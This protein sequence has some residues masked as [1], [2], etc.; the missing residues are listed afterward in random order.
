METTE[1]SFLPAEKVAQLLPES[2]LDGDEQV[3]LALKPSLWLVVFFSFQTVLICLVVALVA[4][5]WL[6]GLLAQWLIIAAGLIALGRIIFALLQWA[7]RVYVLTDQRVIVV[8]GVFTVTIFQCRLEKIQ[9]TFMLLPFLLRLLRLGHI[10]FATAGTAHIEAVWRFCNQP[11]Q[12]HEQIVK[13]ISKDNS[14]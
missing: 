1:P 9:N 3:A 6:K 12:I 2:L 7:S 11:L 13:L 5:F 10:A 4:T 14:T 8:A